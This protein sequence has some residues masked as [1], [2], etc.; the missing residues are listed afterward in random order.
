MVKIDKN[1]AYFSTKELA[2]IFGIS[3]VAIF[4]RIKAGKIKAAKI[5]NSYLIEKEELAKVLRGDLTEDDKKRI[6]EAVKRTIKEYGSVLKMLGK[7]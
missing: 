3:Q 5:G 4:K 6:N 2:E 7:E 1:K